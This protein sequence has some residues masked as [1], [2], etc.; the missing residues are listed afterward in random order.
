[1]NKYSWE[2]SPNLIDMFDSIIALHPSEAYMHNFQ[3]DDILK[4]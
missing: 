3:Y 1:M 4:R 2:S